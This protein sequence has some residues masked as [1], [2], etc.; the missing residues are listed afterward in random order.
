M[1]SK[2]AFKHPWERNTWVKSTFH[3]TTSRS[4]YP[5]NF[6]GTGSGLGPQAP[7]GP[8]YGC[9]GTQGNPTYFSLTIE[10]SGSINFTLDNTAN[11]D[12]DFILWGP[13][14]SLGYFNN[15]YCYLEGYFVYL[16]KNISRND[17]T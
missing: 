15:C 8:D 17:E 1:L 9:L 12:I 2:K 3:T 11:L 5:A 7:L 16:N 4:Q 14:N 6:D 13:F 10:Q